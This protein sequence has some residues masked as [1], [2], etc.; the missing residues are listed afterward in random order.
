MFICKNPIQA[1]HATIYK[2][3]HPLLFP[4]HYQKFKPLSYSFGAYIK[5]LVCRAWW[6][7]SIHPPMEANRKRSRWFPKGK[8]TPFYRAPK[9]PATAQYG[10][11]KT[12][13]TQSSACPASVG[14]LVHQD[15]A[16]A[17]P[18]PKVSFV[19]AENGRDLVRQL[20]E[21]YGVVGDESVDTKAAI[22]IS[23]V[24]ERLKLERVNSERITFQENHQV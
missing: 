8:L 5:H 1:P 9:P 6:W 22:Y 20:E 21:V 4:A 19:V 24:Q 17:Q 18:K 10:S 14:I 16:I 15:Y 3:T 11:T 12:K 23:T 13:P 2:H 7:R